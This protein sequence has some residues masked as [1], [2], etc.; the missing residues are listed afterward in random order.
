MAV[1]SVEVDSKGAVF[2]GRGLAYK[3]VLLQRVVD[4]VAHEG[5]NMVVAHLVTFIRKPTPFYWT[6]ITTR[7]VRPF[8][9]D[10]WDQRTTVYGPWLEGVSRRN[11][12]TRFKG[13]A[14]FRKSTQRLAGEVDR[15]AAPAVEAF[16]KDMNR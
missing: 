10:V 16:I 11:A 2:D 13:Y 1:F 9:T 6:Q 4:D 5:Q 12:A 3:D 15:V 7:K 8:I 14:A